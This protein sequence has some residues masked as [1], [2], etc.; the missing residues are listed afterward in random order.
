LFQLSADTTSLSNLQFSIRELAK[1]F[2]NPLR[3][4]Y[5]IE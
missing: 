1:N 5:N 3:H 2:L 4:L